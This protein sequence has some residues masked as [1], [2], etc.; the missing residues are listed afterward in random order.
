[1]I[2]R[3]ELI[4]ADEWTGEEEYRRYKIT[5]SGVS[6]KIILGTSGATM[7]VNGNEHDEYGFTT[8]DPIGVVAMS[9]KRFRKKI[10]LVAEVNGLDPVKVFGFNEPDVTLVGWGSTKGPAIEAIRLLGEEGTRARFIQIVYMEPFP[11]DAFSEAIEGGGKNLLLE[12]NVTN[13][14]GRLIKEHTG[15][16]FHKS[17]VR[18]DGRSLTPGE[19]AAEARRLL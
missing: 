19:I 8:I 11:S 18:Y 5:E 13:Q 3:G 17:Y 1:V 6:P 9:D 4:E 2:E 12:T 10:R 7:L 16:G 14:L 15:L